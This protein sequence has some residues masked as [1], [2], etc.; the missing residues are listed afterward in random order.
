[1][2]SLQWAIENDTRNS[3][4]V[5]SNDK[6]DDD[7]HFCL[8]LV[9]LM[10]NLEPH[11]KTMAK[12]QTMK[13]CNDI[14]ITKLSIEKHYERQPNSYPVQNCNG[15][16][17]TP[18]MQHSYSPYMRYQSQLLHRDRLMKVKEIKPV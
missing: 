9:G 1:M 5:N 7:H 17:M 16:R 6:P 18:Y 4:P 2:K 3:I 10:K 11:Y 14:E 15:S 13:V 12:F 8:R